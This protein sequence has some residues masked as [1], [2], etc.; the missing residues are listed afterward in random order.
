MDANIL[1][2]INYGYEA[3]IEKSWLPFLRYMFQQLSEDFGFYSI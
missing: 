3:S 1:E 2:Q